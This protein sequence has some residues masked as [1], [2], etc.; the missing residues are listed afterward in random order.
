MIDEIPHFTGTQDLLRAEIGH[1]I[2]PIQKGI[3]EA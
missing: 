2:N 1:E 3:G